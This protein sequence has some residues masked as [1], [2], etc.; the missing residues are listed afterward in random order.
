MTCRRMFWQPVLQSYLWCP[1]RPKNAQRAYPSRRPAQLS[2]RKGHGRCNLHCDGPVL[3]D[4]STRSIRARG[5]SAASF[6]KFQL[7]DLPSSLNLHMAGRVSIHV[8][9]T[10]PGSRSLPALDFSHDGWFCHIYCTITT[11][12]NAISSQLSRS[13]H[14]RRY[15]PAKGTA[16]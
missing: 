9:G 12:R 16:L 3:T 13:C 2:L 14:A 8:G 11:V 10:S 5:C 15:D 6:W 1:Q 7:Y 4:H